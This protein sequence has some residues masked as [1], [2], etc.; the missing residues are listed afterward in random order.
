VQHLKKENIN[1]D[2]EIKTLTKQKVELV[3]I[4]ELQ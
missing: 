2:E 3:E 1:K 4:L